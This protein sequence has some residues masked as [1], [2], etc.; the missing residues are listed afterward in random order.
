MGV[1]EHVCNTSK[2]RSVM[3]RKL[4]LNAI[5]YHF[6]VSVFAT[7]WCVCFRIG[8]VEH[9]CNAYSA[10]SRKPILN[11]M[12]YHFLVVS[13]MSRKPTLNAIIAGSR[14]PLWVPFWDE[15]YGE[16]SS[17]L[18]ILEFRS[19]KW[20]QNQNGVLIRSG[21]LEDDTSQIY[22]S[23]YDSSQLIRASCSNHGHVC[24]GYT[25]KCVCVVNKTE[26]PYQ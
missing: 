4:T 16:N 8:V 7:F 17:E 13:V 23:I 22:Q 25:N 12:L 15:N 14:L 2:I 26:D 21:V 24:A 19:G 18:R 3:S 20:T 5:L 10:V 9:A 6:L 11:A 1:G